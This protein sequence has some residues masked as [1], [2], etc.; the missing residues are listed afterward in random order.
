VLRHRAPIVFG[1]RFLARRWPR[2]MQVPNWLI[3]RVLSFLANALF[4]LRIT[5]EATGLKLVRTDILRAFSLECRRFEF[6][7][8]VVAKAGLMRVPIVERP[9]GYR[10]RRTSAGKKIHWTDGVEAIVTLLVWAWGPR[11]RVFRT[12]VVTHGRLVPREL[13]RLLGEL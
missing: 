12:Q 7:P 10:A 1:S 5:D 6:C 2:G 8:E 11:A 4:G 9:I 3:N 13:E